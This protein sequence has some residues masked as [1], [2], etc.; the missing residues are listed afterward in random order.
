MSLSR[1]NLQLDAG[2]MP[3][4][5]TPS[6]AGEKKNGSQLMKLKPQRNGKSNQISPIKEAV[7]TPGIEVE[8]SLMTLEKVGDRCS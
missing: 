4:R 8:V 5:L 3:S 1:S 7:E 2:L 6:G